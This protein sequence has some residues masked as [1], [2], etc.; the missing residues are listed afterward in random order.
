MVVACMVHAGAAMTV[1]GA[2]THFSS[3]I[4]STA[5]V[6]FRLVLFRPKRIQVFKM[7]STFIVMDA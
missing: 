5:P 6:K 1:I 3:H 7:A 4:V 2:F